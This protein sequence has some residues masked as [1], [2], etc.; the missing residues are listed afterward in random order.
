MGGRCGDDKK[1]TYCENWSKKYIKKKQL[2]DYGDTWGFPGGYKR[3]CSSCEVSYLKACR[4]V[5][6]TENVQPKKYRAHQDSNHYGA[7]ELVKDEHLKFKAGDIIS[8]LLNVD[9]T[10]TNWLNG[11]LN[12]KIGDFPPNYVKELNGK[13]WD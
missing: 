10:S 4:H 3:L 11:E 1:N 9:E 12:G 5:K 6:T 13:E 8:L 2:P 7:P